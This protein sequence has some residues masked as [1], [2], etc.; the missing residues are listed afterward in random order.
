MGSNGIVALGELHEILEDFGYFGIGAFEIF[1]ESAPS[2]T[3]LERAFGGV[4]L[5]GHLGGIS[6]DEFVYPSLEQ[7][8][9]D[10]KSGAFLDIELGG[11]VKGVHDG[12]RGAGGGVDDSD[13]VH[14][15]Y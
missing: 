14:M 6:E 2:V 12:Q 13:V 5:F 4:R 8:R 3:G 15:V 1:F 11:V 7:V 10:V 9:R